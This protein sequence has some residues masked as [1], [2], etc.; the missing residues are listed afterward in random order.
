MKYRELRE[1]RRPSFYL[2][3]AQSR[4]AAGVLH[5]RVTGNPRRE[6]DTLRR[7]VGEI[8]PSVPIT[9]VRTLRAQMD[10]NLNDERLAMLIG[11]TLGVAALL[12]AAVGLYGSLAYMVGQRTRELGVRM[13][14]GATAGDLGRMVLRQGVTLSIAGTVMGAVLS[15]MMARALEGRLFGVRASNVPTLLAAAAV[16]AAV[17]LA[18]SWLPARRAARVDPVN[19]LRAE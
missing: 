16:L 19:A 2:P 8:D 5:V 11:V 17:A 6:L 14:L 1:D 4:A 15:M 7:A 13:A 9:S 10:L 3:L 12:L 18:A